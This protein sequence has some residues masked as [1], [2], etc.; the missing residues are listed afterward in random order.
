MLHTEREFAR[1][2]FA[3]VGKS[4]EF[5]KFFYFFVVAARKKSESLHIF[6]SGAGSEQ[7]G[8]LYKRAYLSATFIQIVIAEKS[9]FAAAGNGKPQNQFH[10]RSFARAVF[11][12]K[13]VNITAINGHINVIHDGFFAVTLG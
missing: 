6:V 5:E 3:R 7:S 4:D 1:A 9:D 12:D 10:R 8:R 2:F 11:T 13:A